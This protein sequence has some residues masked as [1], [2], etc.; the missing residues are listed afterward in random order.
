VCAILR[1]RLKE[2]DISVEFGVELTNFVQDDSGVSITLK[3]AAGQKEE[4]VMAKYIVGADGARGAF[5]FMFDAGAA[6]SPDFRSVAQAGR[7]PLLGRVEPGDGDGNGG[8]QAYRTGYQGNNLS[9]LPCDVVL[10]FSQYWYQ[11]RGNPGGPML[12]FWP[13]DSPC[14]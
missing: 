9:L 1:D 7:Y 3:H 6:D 12:V 5:Y 11:Y 8:G 4:T 13:H 14:P 10:N 2:F